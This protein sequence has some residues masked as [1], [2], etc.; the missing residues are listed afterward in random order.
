[1]GLPPELGEQG[2]RHGARTAGGHRAAADTRDRDDLASGACEE[3]FIGTEK[4]RIPQ[5]RFLDANS[6]IAPDLEQKLPRDSRQ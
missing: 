5:R 1:M 3:G 4:I 6:D 2:E